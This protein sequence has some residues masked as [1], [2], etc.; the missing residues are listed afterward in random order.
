MQHDEKDVGGLCYS[1]SFD[2]DNGCDVIIER[3]NWSYTSGRLEIS[4]EFK[5][6][7][8]RDRLRVG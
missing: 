4:M 5:E 6:G 1:S 8:A 2:Y 3:V 7:Y